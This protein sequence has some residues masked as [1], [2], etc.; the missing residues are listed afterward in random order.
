MSK[1]ALVTGASRGL[2]AAIAAALAADGWA[3]AVNHYDPTDTA[4]HR[5]VAAIERAGGRAHA[6]KFDV[7][8]GAAA[9]RGLEDVRHALGPVD[10]VVNNATGPQ[11]ELPL[12]QQTWDDHL[13]QLEFFV[14][15]PLQLLQL[16]LP[17]WRARR[18]GRVI[19]IGSEFAETGHPNFAHYVA[20]KGAMAAMTRS[21][22][23][24]LAP[25][26]INVNLVAPGWIPVERHAGTPQESLDAYL[27]GTPLGRFGTPP[28]VAAAVAFLASDKA[29]FITG[30]KIAVDG[31]RTLG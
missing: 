2:G 13:R 18:S 25:D 1:V 30:Q 4:A 28:D 5:V 29:D 27:A 11:P 20:A 17:D 12:M 22:A 16:L 7:T 31:G 24:E 6:E 19:N 10:L 23:R 14:K 3:V 15:A 8:D 26:A 9:A 21:W